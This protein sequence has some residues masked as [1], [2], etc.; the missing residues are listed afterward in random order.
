MFKKLVNTALAVTLSVAMVAPAA[1]VYAEDIDAPVETVAENESYDSNNST[2]TEN[3][4]T[5]TENTAGGTVT[6]NNGGVTTNAGEVTTNNGTVATNTGVVTTNNA[7]VTE[8]NGLVSTNETTG[9]IA[10]NNGED[11]P[12][13]AG[14]LDAGV[15]TNKG[16]ITT[17][18]GD[19]ATNTS[20]GTIQT[21]GEDGVVETNDG[22]IT[23][24]K[25]LV[26]ANN[27]IVTDEHPERGI[28]E[29]RGTVEVN[30]GS[31]GVMNPVSE[32]DPHPSVGEN[33]G[34]I[35]YMN[36]YTEVGTNTSTGTIGL[37]HGTV[38]ENHGSIDQIGMNPTQPGNIRGTVALNANDGS[39]RN[40]DGD[41]LRNE[42]TILM[43]NT[44]GTV[45][46]ADGGV[47]EVNTGTATGT[48][49]IKINLSD[50]EIGE[51]NVLK[52]MWQI[53]CAK[54]G[55]LFYTDNSTSVDTAEIYDCVNA[56]QTE[57][58]LW[59][60][61]GENEGAVFFTPAD[62]EQEIES[63]TISGGGA[64][65]EKQ[66]DGSWK[67]FGI[68]KDVTLNVKFVGEPDPQPVQ[69]KEEP[70]ESD[71]DSSSSNNNKTEDAQP[72]AQ[73]VNYTPVVTAASTASAL[74]VVTATPSA[75]VEAYAPVLPYHA[76]YA[77]VDLS[78][79]PTDISVVATDANEELR[80]A[81]VDL[82]KSALAASGVQA[83]EVFTGY[84]GTI[85]TG[86][87]GSVMTLRGI[88]SADPKFNLETSVFVAFK[89]PITGEITYVK[90]KINVDG[91]ISFEVP[92]QQCE[93]SVVYANK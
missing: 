39:I 33:R 14:T 8:N 29:N 5:I 74:A 71:D 51:N 63:M 61:T 66:E 65:V 3:N 11:D 54:I 87:V 26:K 52:Q 55:N 7:T 24:N 77:A 48:G 28:N 21:N 6:T 59:E 12:G 60:G 69:P 86:S 76:A 40:N 37:V 4:G 79:V 46:N 31:I 47:I 17:N 64:T 80:K 68:T 90:P 10:T 44:E 67:V 62:A 25:G 58:Y 1:V 16:V 13:T 82:M 22:G 23:C 73:P 18:N 20:T 34:N 57:L 2:V 27:G 89:N 19:V 75:A 43:N 72:A 91:S 38:T 15:E 49:T 9:Q 41:V 88:M 32:S 85:K 53:V 78:G 56:G 35:G 45:V 50:A 42:G 92:F 36:L 84:T 30:N 70:K 81:C 93:F 83:K